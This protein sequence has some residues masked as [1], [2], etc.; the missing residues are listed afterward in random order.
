MD[1]KHNAIFFTHFSTLMLDYRL[2]KFFSLL[3]SFVLTFWSAKK[4]I[5]FNVMWL[6]CKCLVELFKN[7]ISFLPSDFEVV[8]ISFFYTLFWHMNEW[9]TVKPISW[10]KNIFVSSFYPLV[11]FYFLIEKY[12][13]HESTLFIFTSSQKYLYFLSVFFF[14][15]YSHVWKVKEQ[16]I[17]LYLFG[18]Y[19][20][21]LRSW[22]FFEICEIEFYW[23]N[24]IF[25]FHT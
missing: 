1:E 23:E 10:W 24:N 12:L 25:D 7:K 22:C 15:F 17:H 11:F 6:I 21:F 9:F 5:C 16:K 20:R 3:L 19:F 8:D 2:M 18:F 4:N 13:F 14:F